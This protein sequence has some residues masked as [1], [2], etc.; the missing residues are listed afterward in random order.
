M[1]F[2]TDT[3][4]VGEA[5]LSGAVKQFL[6]LER[7]RR[8]E[9]FHY[10]E[11]VRG[12]DKGR[13][14]A[15]RPDN[16]LSAN[17]AKYITDVHTGYF[18]G[19]P[20]TLEFAGKRLQE[21]MVRALAEAD[22]NGTLYSAAR[23]MSICG[24]GYALAYLTPKGVRLAR[25][26]PRETFVITCGIREEVVAAVRVNPMAHG[27][28]AGELYTPGLLR[29]WEFDGRRATL[30]TAQKLPLSAL[31]VSRF[32][33]NLSCMGDFEPVCSLLDAYNLL[34]SGSMDDMQSVAN[35]F[36][37]LYGMQGTTKEDID[38]ANST[39]V[40]SLAENGKAEFVVKNMNPQALQLLRDTLLDDMLQITMTPNLNDEAFGTGSSGVALEYKL[41]GAEQCRSAKERGFAPGLYHLIALFYQGMSLLGTPVEG[42]CSARFYKNLPQDL[43]KLCGNLNSLGD[44]LSRKTR[45]ELLPFITDAERELQ[46]Q[47]REQEESK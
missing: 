20:P 13:V 18:M 43:T 34:L 30:G 40:L 25:L 17:Y 10:Y 12:V 35:A 16:R 15:G 2:K 45:L 1:V 6:M 21:R 42:E 38:R 4:D 41:W 33:N 36:L 9:L 29:K 26:D 11:G 27:A 8:E 14:A 7:P 47:R 44:L 19:V 24:E 3:P 22:L 46:R 5:I 23:D 31:P 32:R 28:A 37:A 39:R